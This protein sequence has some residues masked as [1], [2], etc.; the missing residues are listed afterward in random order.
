MIAGQVTLTVHRHGEPNRWGEHDPAD[1]RTHRIR[2]CV[3]APGS[4][5]EAGEWANTVE[6]TLTVFAGFGA[7]VRANDEVTVDG[8]VNDSGRP[9]RWQV[10]GDPAR[11]RAPS[12][13]R[14][15]VSIALQRTE[16]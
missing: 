2:R 16:G 8:V 4:S 5:T 15:G 7:D 3:V 14:A 9:V 13:S 10:V 6:S 11:W 12:G 1:E